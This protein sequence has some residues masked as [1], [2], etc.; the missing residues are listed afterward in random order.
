ME[1]SRTYK[2]KEGS[3]S[4][5]KVERTCEK[6]WTIQVIRGCMAF[7][8]SG[9]FLH[10]K[11]PCLFRSLVSGI[12]AELAA[13]CNQLEFTAQHFGCSLAHY[14]S[15]QEYLEVVH[16]AADVVVQLELHSQCLLVVDYFQLR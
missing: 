12:S 2:S 11:K 9:L 15:F 7:G 4:L 14:H 5:K 10:K 1:I 8:S 3:W 16:Q 6:Q 13:V